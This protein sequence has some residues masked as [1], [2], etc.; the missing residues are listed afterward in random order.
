MVAEA[1]QHRRRLRLILI[2]KHLRAFSVRSD[3]IAMRKFRLVGTDGEGLATTETA[4]GNTRLSKREARSVEP[5][6]Q[7]RLTITTVPGTSDQLR[8]SLKW[9]LRV[10]YV[11]SCCALSD[12]NTR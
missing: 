11:D 4:K 2:R 5:F 8:L 1:G 10:S 12:L 7:H 9:F 6:N 3:E